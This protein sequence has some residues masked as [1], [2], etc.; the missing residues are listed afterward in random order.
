MQNNTIVITGAGRRIGRGLALRFAQ[1]KWNVVIHYGSSEEAA[2]QTLRD[3]ESLGARGLLV[4]AD[5]RDRAAFRNAIA[6][7]AN[8]FG[9]L[10]VLVNNA[11]IYPPTRPIADVTQELW[12]QVIETNLSSEFFAAQAAA[13]IMQQQPINQRGEQGRIINFASL[14]AYQIWRDRLPYNV[15]KGAVLQLIRALARALAPTI[16]VNGIA[17]GTIEIPE[18]PAPGT[19]LSADRIPARR[20]G[21]IDDIFNAVWFLANDATYITGQTLLIDGGLSIAQ[22]TSQE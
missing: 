10:D 20:Y 7:G 11:A 13:Q 14:G 5:V 9:S 15:A 18:D 22:E 8:H 17:P 21:T 16:P 19:L 12:D 2:Q 3:V 1:R 4:Q 6:T